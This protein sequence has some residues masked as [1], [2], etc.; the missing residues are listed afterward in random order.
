MSQRYWPF[1]DLVV[2]TPRL[3][4][5]P[6]DDELAVALAPMATRDIFPDGR[7]QFQLDWLYLPSPEKERSSLQYWWRNRAE[8][9]PA[10]WKLDLAVLVDG[11]PAGVQDLSADRFPLRRSV[12]TASW[13]ARRFQGRG[14]GIEMRQA[15]LHLAFDGLEALEAHSAAFVSNERSI[16]V[17]RSVGYEEN[18]R[19]LSLRAGNEPET[20]VRFR[21]TAEGFSSSRRDDIEVENLEPCL[22]VLGLR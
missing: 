7:S 4:L 18:G 9:S 6:I 11:Q 12:V 16:A 5:R 10:H 17:S 19:E 2:R 8:L 22:A 3:E 20:I 21:M 13:L 1:F 14:L 15:V